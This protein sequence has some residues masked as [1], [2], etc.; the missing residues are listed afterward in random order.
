MLLF[1]MYVDWLGLTIIIA[2]L[3]GIVAAVLYLLRH[4]W[5]LAKGKKR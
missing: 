5:R 2:L 3:T 1:M 4:L